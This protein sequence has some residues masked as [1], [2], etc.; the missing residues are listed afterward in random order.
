MNADALAIIVLR[1]NVL[2]ALHGIAPKFNVQYQIKTDTVPKHVDYVLQ[3][4]ID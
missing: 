1:I 4:E 2:T 3:T